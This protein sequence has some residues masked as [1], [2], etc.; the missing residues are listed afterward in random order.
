[1]RHLYELIHQ[2]NQD[3]T[4]VWIPSHIGIPGN[5]MADRLANEGVTK[6]YT[7]IEINLEITEIYNVIDEFCKDRWQ[8]AWSK[9][10]HEQFLMIERNVK[11]VTQHRYANRRMAVT[12]NRLRFGQCGLNIYLH[13]MNIHAT[14]LSDICKKPETVTH[15]I[16]ECASEMTR[17][18]TDNCRTRN[19]Q[20]TI[21]NV[22]NDREL[23]RSICSLNKRQL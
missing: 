3:V 14:G 2:T 11:S 5:E 16:T 17:Y 4:L 18:V 21:E 8:N 1:M 13:K 19:I 9:H 12:V 20:C 23:L 7:E 10:A 15:Y 6:P 22:L